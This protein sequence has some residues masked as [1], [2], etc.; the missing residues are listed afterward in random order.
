MSKPLVLAYSG[1]E[2]C[3]KA[4]EWLAANKIDATVRPIVDEPPTEAE[5]AKWISASELPVKK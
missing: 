5:L 3:R 1:C 4:L 2:T